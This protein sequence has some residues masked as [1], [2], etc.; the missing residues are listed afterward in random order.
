MKVTVT[1][2]ASG[3]K[4][5]LENA[6]KHTKIVSIIREALRSN[7]LYPGW[8]RGDIFGKPFCKKITASIIE[9]EI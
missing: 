4:G 2:T 7:D 5:S 9:V 6:G 8:E 3:V 1:I